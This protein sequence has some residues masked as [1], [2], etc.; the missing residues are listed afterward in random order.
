MESII[1]QFSKFLFH[2]VEGHFVPQWSSHSFCLLEYLLSLAFLWTS[3]FLRDRGDHKHHLMLFPAWLR[4]RTILLWK[5]RNKHVIKNSISCARLQAEQV[6]QTC[7]TTRIPEWTGREIEARRHWFGGR[8]PRV[9]L[10]VYFLKHCV[11]GG[12]HPS[13]PSWV[14][15]GEGCTCQGRHAFVRGQPQGSRTFRFFEIRISHLLS[16]TVD[17]R[18]AGMFVLGE[19][20]ASA[21]LT[22]VGILGSQTCH[23]VSTF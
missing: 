14:C 19:S 2:L 18:L 11:C 5:R 23:T 10:S 21:H 3:L 16:A 8:R 1:A 6:L 22:T 12:C 17:S 15:V 13:T 4:K 7:D 9:S 20:P